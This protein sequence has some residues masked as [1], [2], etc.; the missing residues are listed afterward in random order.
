MSHHNFW[1]YLPKVD[2]TKIL[3]GRK[4]IPRGFQG[5][6]GRNHSGSDVQSPSPSQEGPLI[7]KMTFNIHT[8]KSH[9]FDKLQRDHLRLG[10]HSSQLELKKNLFLVFPVIT[11]HTHTLFSHKHINN[12]SSHICTQYSLLQAQELLTKKKKKH[13]STHS[14][15][16]VLLVF[17][18]F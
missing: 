3:C 1:Q 5:Q 6:L 12:S 18:S 7:F 13:F 2:A 14:I 17:L 10:P 11:K 15:H 8:Q 9:S 16:S 4:N